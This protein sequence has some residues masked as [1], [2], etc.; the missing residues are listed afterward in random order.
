[1]ADQ[2]LVFDRD[3]F[4]S[5]AGLLDAVEAVAPT[6]HYGRKVDAPTAF[7]DVR[8]GDWLYFINSGGRD[9]VGQVDGMTDKTI[10]IAAGFQDQVSGV[11]FGGPTSL[12]RANWSRLQVH[13][14]EPAPTAETDAEPASKSR[15]AGGAAQAFPRSLRPV[16]SAVQLAAAPIFGAGPGRPDSPGRRSR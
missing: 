14:W 1:F 9:F 4:L 5:A 16:Q 10:R 6:P 12:R 7:D 11:R 3:A 13:L 8:V 2:H 15:S